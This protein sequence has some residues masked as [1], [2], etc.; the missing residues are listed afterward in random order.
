MEKCAYK[1]FVFITIPKINLLFL[2]N[3]SKTGFKFGYY[4]LVIPRLLS[5]FEGYLKFA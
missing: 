2:P 3:G 4:V 1:V 5:N